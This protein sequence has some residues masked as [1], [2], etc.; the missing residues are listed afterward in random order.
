MWSAWIVAVVLVAACAG[1]AAWVAVPA[2][3]HGASA[4][5]YVAAVPLIY[6]AV[7]ALFVAW[8]FALAWIFRAPRPPEARI[9]LRATVRLVATEYWTLAGAPLRMLLYRSLVPRPRPARAGTP[10]LLL[11]GV[12]CN[13]GVWSSFTGFFR[14]HG[15]APVYALSYGPPLAS[16]ELFADQVHACIEAICAENGAADVMVVTHSMG[17]LI[18][19]AYLRRYGA[20][21]VRRLVAIA[22]PFRG[23]VHAWCLVGASL[24]QLRPGNAWLTALD[25]AAPRAGP[26]IV[27]IW[28]RHDSMVAPQTSSELPGATNIALTGIGHNALLQDAGVQALVLEEYRRATTSVSAT[29]VSLA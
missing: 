4:W 18:A 25:A 13:A 1:Y 22:A 6:F 17:G 11:H 23:S 24:S 2:V 12:L 19:L 20:A 21:R 28:S 7:L 9:G 29:S 3:A 26:P 10:V 16:I 14:R 15:V 5:P 8:Y 27:S